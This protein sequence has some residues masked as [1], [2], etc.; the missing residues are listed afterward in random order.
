MNAEESDDAHQL[1]PTRWVM[2]AQDRWLKRNGRPAEPLSAIGSDPAMGGEDQNAAAPRIG[3]W[4]DFPEVVPGKTTPEGKDTLLFV[5][6]V[7]GRYRVVQDVPVGMDTVG[8]GRSP[9]DLAKEMGLRVVA[10]ESGGRDS[11]DA[12]DRSGRLHFANNRAY[13]WWKFREAL[14]PE[15]GEDLELP[16]DQELLVELTAVHYDL[17]TRG[18]VVEDK[19]DIKKKIGR[20]P[21]KADAVVY[22]YN[23]RPVVVGY[24][25]GSPQSPSAASPALGGRIGGF[26]QR[27]GF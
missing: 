21:N 1:I 16:P 13:W 9:R 15:L 24:R 12:T 17:G 19:D 11:P 23:V 27:K 20:S 14:D 10:M 25:G 5:A 3:V 6:K 18:I 2:L 4:F 26:G 8:V 7:I 22:A